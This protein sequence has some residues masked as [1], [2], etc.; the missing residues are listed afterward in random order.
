M[1]QVVKN[2]HAFKWKC[3]RCETWND[4]ERGVCKKC[5][6]WSQQF[7]TAYK[8]ESV[9]TAEEQGF[10]QDTAPHLLIELREIRKA[11]KELTELVREVSWNQRA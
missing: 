6:G 3:G 10:Y 11:I 9:L 8:V 7:A 1:S 4:S 5:G 2:P